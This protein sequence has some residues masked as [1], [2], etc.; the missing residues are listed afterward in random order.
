MGLDMYLT[1]KRF[2]WTDDEKIDSKKLQE[3]M[4]TDYRVQYVELEIGYWRKANQIHK[5]FVENVQE[6]NDDC[7][8]YEV[9]EEKLKELLNVVN[10]ALSSQSPEILLPTQGGFFF[11]STEYDKWYVRDLQSTKAIIEKWLAFP[12]KDKYDVY[13]GSS[14]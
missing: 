7:D 2:I 13:Y 8:T 11:G 4:N 1:A 10:K 6:N 12:D 14:W 3:V 5:W 9:S